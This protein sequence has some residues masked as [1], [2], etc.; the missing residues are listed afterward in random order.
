MKPLKRGYKITQLFGES[1]TYYSQ[2]GFKAHEGID[3]IPTDSDWN[4]HSMEDGVVLRDIDT[5]RDNYGIYCVI[6]NKDKKRAWWYCHLENNNLN[7][8][9]FVKAGDVIGKMGSTGKVTGAHLH[10]GLRLSDSSGNAINTDNGF[11]GFIDPLPLLEELNK[12]VE[13]IMDLS[14]DISTEVEDKFKL[15]EVSRYNKY[16]SYNELIDDWVKLAGECEYEKEE[17]EKYK[18]EAR[19]LREVVESQAEEIQEAKKEIE[20]LSQANAGHRAEIA[21]L[22]AQ[23]AEVSRERDSL[24]D[25]C[26][27]YEASI[28]K[29]RTKIKELEDKLLSQNP[30][31]DYSA[32]DLLS[33]FFD[34]IF[35]RV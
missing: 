19:E 20:R 35:H 27:G 14:D 12:E 21:Q 29:L 13:G 5:P 7:T 31:K 8:G 6:W 9:Q 33:A 16:W 28:P 23:F 34:K 22:Q 24:L 1:P 26:K 25:C 32:K 2:W 10:L 18:K 11:K 4:I 3:L 15:K 30:L 17:K